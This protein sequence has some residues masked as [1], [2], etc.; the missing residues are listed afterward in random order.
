LDA[1]KYLIGPTQ[2][3]VPSGST[4]YNF[5]CMLPQKIPTNQVEKHGKIYYKLIATVSVPWSLDS[6]KTCHFYVFRT[7]DLNTVAWL[8]N[9]R[10]SVLHETFRSLI[11]SEC[12]KLHFNATIPKSGYVPGEP[13]EVTISMQNSSSVDIDHVRVF[14]DRELFYYC[15]DSD[16]ISDIFGPS[17][18]REKKEEKNLTVATGRGVKAGE[19]LQYK[20]SLMVPPTHSSTF[21]ICKVLVTDYHLK[22]VVTPCGL[23]NNLHLKFPVTIGT[24]A[25]NQ[26]TSTPAP[27]APIA[28]PVPTL[29]SAPPPEI[30]QRQESLPP[31]Y[32][33]CAE[34]NPNLIPPQSA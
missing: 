10:N 21:E 27:T 22:I 1:V 15:T 31:S 20:I 2:E 4:T 29:P 26:L 12:G 5:S 33:Q 32:D 7:Y 24:V 17:F 3:T 6:V 11:F 8:K 25:I 9:P 19:S 18:R 23:H 16:I 34:T 13:I 14:F 30:L 28:Q